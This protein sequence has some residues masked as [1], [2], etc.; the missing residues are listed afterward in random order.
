MP[1]ISFLLSVANFKVIS[2]IDIYICERGDWLDYGFRRQ[3]SLEYATQ[4]VNEDLSLSIEYI[5]TVYGNAFES[6]V[7]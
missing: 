3:H 5:Y 6:I 7:I 4:T 2:K 1:G